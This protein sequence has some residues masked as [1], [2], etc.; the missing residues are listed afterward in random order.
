MLGRWSIKQTLRA[1]VRSIAMLLVTALVCTFLTVGFDLEYS[2][3]VG[4]ENIRETFLVAA[5]P[6]FTALVDRY[7]RTEAQM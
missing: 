5:V 1:P 2:A 6:S 4:R 3:R 7:G